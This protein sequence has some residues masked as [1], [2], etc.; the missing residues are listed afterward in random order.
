[1]LLDDRLIDGNKKDN[2]KDN[3]MVVISCLKTLW[4]SVHCVV[5]INVHCLVTITFS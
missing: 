4:R 2:K 3:E 5:P 1:M